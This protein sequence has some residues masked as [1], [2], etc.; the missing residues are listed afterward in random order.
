[1]TTAHKTAPVDHQASLKQRVKASRRSV[2]RA[3]QPAAAPACEPVPTT[4]A[5]AK[6]GE[7]LEEAWV[8]YNRLQDVMT[9]ENAALL[10]PLDQHCV[11]L[12]D[13]LELAVSY[14]RA[15][16]PSGMLT[17]LAVTFH[18][19]DLATTGSEKVVREA[20][21]SRAERCLH[22]IAAALCGMTGI[23][24][25]GSC[26]GRYMSSK[27]DKLAFLSPKVAR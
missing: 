15:A 7:I 18:A 13:E 2:E 3:M 5:A 24:R 14:T 22:S 4:C 17:Q 16:S 11:R 10:E 6:L 12:I 21:A 27:N 8:E 9:V 20:A 25:D 19:V 23:D 1:M 26:G